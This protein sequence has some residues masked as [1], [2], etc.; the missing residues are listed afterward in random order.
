MSDPHALGRTTLDPVT[1]AGCWLPQ[2]TIVTG[3]RTR[4]RGEGA[5]AAAYDLWDASSKRTTR[6]RL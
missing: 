1:A 5:A 2:H 3:A 4:H 6:A